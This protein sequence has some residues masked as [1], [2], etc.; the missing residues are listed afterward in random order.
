MITAVQIRERQIERKA[1]IEKQ[2]AEYE[3]NYTYYENNEKK[4]YSAATIDDIIK[5]IEKKALD[6]TS[7]C[8]INIRN[9]LKPNVVK[10]LK[11]L[12]YQVYRL[13]YEIGCFTT[14]HCLDTVICWGDLPDFK[15]RN[16]KITKL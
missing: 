2:K 6:D 3:R 14:L 4:Y 8:F 1:E 7:S 10:Q 13:D 12:G 16:K 5:K 9:L 15:Y 11:N